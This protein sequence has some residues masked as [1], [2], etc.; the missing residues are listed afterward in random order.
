MLK[1]LIIT[2]ALFLIPATAN[3]TCPSWEYDASNSI[4]YSGSDLWSAKA[5]SV[6]AGGTSNSTELSRCNIRTNNAPPR[7]EG[8]VAPVPDFELHF[9]ANG[10]QLELRT[11]GNCDTTLL[12]NTGGGNWYFDDDDYGDGDAKI[13]LTRPTSGVY[14]IWVGTYD[15]EN[16]DARLE[17]ESF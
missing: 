10:Y 8:Y 2:L 6:V 14:D 4:Y 3:A 7:A 17:L 13:R 11:V 1:R 5:H 15:N 12:I 16:C 9:T